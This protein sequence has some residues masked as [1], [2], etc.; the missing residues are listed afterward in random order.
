LGAAWPAP[1]IIVPEG[2]TAAAIREVSD[3]HASRATRSSA[4]CLS[5]MADPMPTVVVALVTYNSEAVLPACL[6]SLATA[7]AGSGPCRLVVADNAS[8]DRSVALVEELCPEATIVRLDRNRGYAAGVNAAVDA[9]P[10]ADA[11]LVLNPDARLGAGSLRLLLDALAV[12]GT[13]IAVP[14]LVDE[15][16]R[17]QHSLR[18]E[19]TVGRALGEAVLGGAR[20]GRFRLLGE[21]VT[22]GEHYARPGLADWATGAVMLISRRCLDAV[23]RWD[24]SFFLYSEETDFALRARDAGY[25]V[26]YVPEAVAVHLGGDVMA[27][28]SLWGLL[29]FNRARLYRRRHGP[30]ATGAFV[31]ALM[32]GEAVRAVHGPPRHRAA[33]RAL[34]G[35]RTPHRPPP[36]AATAPAYVCFSA[37]DWWYHNRAHSDFQLM[38]RVARDRTVLFVNSIGMRMPLPGRSPG[39]LRRIVRKARSMSHRLQAPLPDV[40]GFHVLTPVVLP[41]YGSRWGRAVNAWVV[42]VQVARAERRLGIEDPLVVATIPTA[43][44]VVRRLPHRSLVFNRS[45]KHSAF[46]EV[47]Q[48]SIGGL[49]Q[50][51]LAGAD[52]VLY[53]SRSLLA[54]EAPRTA[55]RAHFLDHGVDLELFRPRPPEEEPGDLRTI[56]HPRIGFFGGFDDYIVD[57]ALLEKV[58]AEI[59]DAHLVLI[60]DATCPMGRLER[61]PNV[62]WLGYR[63]YEEIPRYGSGF[64]VAL[65][66]W[67]DN[68][69]IRHSNPIKLKEYLALGLPVVSTDFPE[70]HHYAEWVSIAAGPEDFV[71]RV[72]KELGDHDAVEGER[73]RAAVAGDS[74]DRRS[75]ELMALCEQ[76]RAA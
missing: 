24:E 56:P 49:E 45:D 20:A 72:R 38:R 29:T 8:T 12:P 13:G 27:S 48:A 31:G 41:F 70:A 10:A 68:E 5:V 32:A 65:M 42:R 66:P 25:A 36:G 74:W 71:A 9:A 47:D 33:L 35:R 22:R 58:A 37:Q 4:R 3:D 53:V 61:L 63:P 7:T 30:V 39:A 69:W 14:R 21:M 60:G 62:H 40:P 44:E 28:P 11:V 1:L 34:L 17:L 75:Q 52:H 2:R 59:P 50:A 6:S 26:R 18:R 54:E 73:R 46:G 76:G 67:L 51:L 15:A 43:W 64:D 57:F 19:P 55:E 16:G 23:G